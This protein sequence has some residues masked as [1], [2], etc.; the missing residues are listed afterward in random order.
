M[1]LLN[2]SGGD[3]KMKKAAVFLCLIVLLFSL[4]AIGGQVH[5][6]VTFAATELLGR[7]T[8]TS[9]TVNVVPSANGQVYFQYGTGSG[10]YTGQT[11]T[12]GLVSG[13][14]TDVVI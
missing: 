9:V 2:L 8:D 6:A 14:P 10:V 12:A 7:P 4:S 13:T 1:K 11:S 3:K 5:A